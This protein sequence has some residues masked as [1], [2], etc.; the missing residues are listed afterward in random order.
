MILISLGSGVF[1]FAGGGS[2]IGRSVAMVVVFAFL[3]HCVRVFA[4][5]GGVPIES[6]IGLA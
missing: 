6:K 5:G 4:V 1:F 3:L 2:I